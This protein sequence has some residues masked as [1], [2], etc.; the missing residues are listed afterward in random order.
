VKVTIL[1]NP[2]CSKS[3]NSL[4]LL[5]EQGIE[6]DVRLYLE[7]PPTEDE[8]TSILEMLAISAKDLLRRGEPEYKELGLGNQNL[9]EQQLIQLMIKHP[10]LIERPIV[11]A[12]GKA[13]IGR[14]PEQVLNLL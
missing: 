12:G 11:I 10:K 7:N 6:P 3:R 13:V 8:L 14:P 5:K 9:S 4:A 1:H 2:R